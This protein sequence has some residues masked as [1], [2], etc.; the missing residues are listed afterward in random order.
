[1]SRIIGSRRGKAKRER[2]RARRELEMAG[3]SIRLTL[4]VDSGQLTAFP[5]V[6]GS[7][8]SAIQFEALVAEESQSRQT[9]EALIP[10][11]FFDEL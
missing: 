8:H 4:S 3:G 11:C 1:M 5:E 10:F 2:Q 7:A 9:P 6:E